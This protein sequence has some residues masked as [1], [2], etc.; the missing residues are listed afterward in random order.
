MLDIWVEAAVV[1][2]RSAV[3]V[4]SLKLRKIQ[5]TNVRVQHL[6]D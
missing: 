3:S 5:R 6:L 4:G 2:R 1:A